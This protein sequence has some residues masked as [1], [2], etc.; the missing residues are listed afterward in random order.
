MSWFK[1]DDT[2]YRSK[3]VRKL[4]ADRLQAVGLWTMCGVWSADNLTDGFVPWEVV[5]SWD[6]SRESADRLITVG[7]WSEAEVDDEK[8]IR[9]HDWTDYQPTREQVEK[10]RNEARERMRK[11]R[12]GSR[13]Q[14]ELSDSELDETSDDVRT[15]EDGTGEERSSHVHDPVPS[16]P[17]VPTGTTSGAAKKR[18]ARIPAD[19]TVSEAMADW[20][21]IKCPNIDRDRETEKFVNYWTATP[22]AKG[23]KLDWKKTWM[24]WMLTA[25]ERLPRHMRNVV[26]PSRSD[27][28][29]AR[30]A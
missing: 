25:E 17:V 14:E 2:F 23:L 26:R 4:G 24:N 16:R 10:R 1:V 9:F 3:K 30:Q 7:L 21:K 20:S 13:E 8:G 22:G 28:P 5:E 27:S 19:F 6:P 15:N 29:W 18:G 11:L 12:G